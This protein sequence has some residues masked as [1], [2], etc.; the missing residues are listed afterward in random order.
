MATNKCNITR[1]A[2][3]LYN[4]VKWGISC[5]K[6][7]NNRAIIENYQVYLACP[8]VTTIICN[9]DDCDNP[10]VISQCSL[11]VTD[12]TVNRVSEIDT[13]DLVDIIFSL[14][15]GD[16]TGGTLPFTYVWDFDDTYLTS[17]NGILSSELQLKL[18]PGDGTD[19]DHLVFS[20]SLKITDAA[21]CEVTTR[22]FYV[23]GDLIIDDG[24]V[25]CPNPST[26][27]LIQ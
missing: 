17:T 27:S 3:E 14:Q 26:L 9:P 16:Y 23:G 24:Y 11:E 5:D 7:A 18:K 1:Y 21:G 15:I 22:F 20:V 2:L 10:T 6:N 8:E 12:L 19:L 13:D 25:P 4:S